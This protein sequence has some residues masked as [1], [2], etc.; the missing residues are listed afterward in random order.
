MIVGY[1]FIRRVDPR[2]CSTDEIQPVSFRNAVAKPHM[3][4]P[5]SNKNLTAH[6]SNRQPVFSKNHFNICFVVKHSNKQLAQ[7][8]SSDMM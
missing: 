3:F 6:G 7:P 8:T 4:N 2:I 5:P 1:T